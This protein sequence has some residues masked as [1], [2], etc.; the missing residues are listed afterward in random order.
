MMRY[1]I[2]PRDIFDKHI[3][4]FGYGFLSIVKNM[5]N[6]IGKNIIKNISGKYGQKLLNHGK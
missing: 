6:N 2:E 4:Y 3:R 1:S 5:S